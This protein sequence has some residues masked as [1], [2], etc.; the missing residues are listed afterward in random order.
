VDRFFFGEVDDGEGGHEN[1][2]RILSTTPMAPSATKMPMVA[3]K[4]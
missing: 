3:P 4:P 1:S 2:P